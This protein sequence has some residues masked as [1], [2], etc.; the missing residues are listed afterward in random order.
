M[1]YNFQ[2]GASVV[3]VASNGDDLALVLANNTIVLANRSLG[4][5][6]VKP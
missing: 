1:N 2:F 3:G 5:N 6:L 4:I